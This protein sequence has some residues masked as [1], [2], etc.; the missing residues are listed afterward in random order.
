M[1][2]VGPCIRDLYQWLSRQMDQG[3]VVLEWNPGGHFGHEADR[4][5]RAFAWVCARQAACGDE[6]GRK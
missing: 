6:M 5:A 1:A 3:R 2:A 4:T